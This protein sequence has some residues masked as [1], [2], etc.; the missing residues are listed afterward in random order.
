MRTSAVDR[1]LRDFL[2]RLRTSNFER[3][4][5]PQTSVRSRSN[6]GKTR[7]RQ[8]A[9]I[10]FSKKKLDEKKND[11][12]FLGFLEFLID[13]G[14]AGRFWTSKSTSLSNFASGGPI[15]RSV[16]PLEQSVSAL[17]AR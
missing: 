2:W 10:D 11:Q 14:G 17:I 13:F 4:F 6:F 1:S 16:Q 3:P 9:K 8:F 7:F 12:F 5:T 15:H